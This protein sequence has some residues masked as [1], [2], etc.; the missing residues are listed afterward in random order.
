MIHRQLKKVSWVIG[1]LVFTLNPSVSWAQNSNTLTVLIKNIELIQGTLELQLASDSLQFNGSTEANLNHVRSIKVTAHE[2]KVVFSNL[3]NGDYALAIYQ[4]LNENDKLD[5][6][7][8]GI[9]SEPFAFSNDA[10]R[11]FGPPYFEQTKFKI[12]GGRNHT[13]V[14]N[15][16][17]RKPSKQK[18]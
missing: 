1:V 7:K 9:P 5:K 14:L 16:I 10:L 6:K 17:Y 8:F 2:M 15:M 11:K 4:D 18:K 12:D 13:Q 3:P